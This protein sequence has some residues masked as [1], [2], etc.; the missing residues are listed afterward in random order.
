EDRLAR[1]RERAS[2][3]GRPHE[4]AGADEYDLALGAELL[5]REARGIRAAA[6]VDHQGQAVVP[7]ER[8]DPGIRRHCGHHTGTLGRR[9]L[10]RRGGR[11]KLQVAEECPADTRGVTALA[12]C[13]PLLAALAAPGVLV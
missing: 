3:R 12:L 11:K 1:I 10:R 13:A 9:Q 8:G 7:M 2:A 4:A 5:G 6:G